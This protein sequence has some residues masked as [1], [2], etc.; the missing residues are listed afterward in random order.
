MVADLHSRTLT[1]LLCN[2]RYGQWQS[3]NTTSVALAGAA[4]TKDFHR[5]GHHLAP[6]AL[7]RRSESVREVLV[8]RRHNRDSSRY[9]DVNLSH[10]N[11]VVGSL[12][13]GASSVTSHSGRVWDDVCKDVNR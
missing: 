2:R 9:P 4:C 13:H 11:A 8:E 12:T 3:N 10:L 6:R 7:D 1:P 5:Y